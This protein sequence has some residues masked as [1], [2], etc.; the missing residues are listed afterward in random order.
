MRFVTSWLRRRPRRLEPERA[1]ELWARC[2]PPLPHNELM[3]VEQETMEAMI[4]SSSLGRVL[5]VGTGTGRYLRLLR[6]RGARFLVG[7]DRSKAMLER[8][9][10]T[11]APLVRGDAGALPLG[12]NA[13]DLVVASLV[14]G[15]IPD[16]ALW[17]REMAR[18]LDAGGSLLYSDFHP[19]WAARGWE[20]TFRSADGRFWRVP[21]HAHALEDHRD[22]HAAWG[23]DVVE[24]REA[25]ADAC[26]VVHAKKR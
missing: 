8:A 14:V 24:I 1:Y 6:G 25:G 2:Y 5:D 26:I 19:S 4:P 3:R 12:G 22:A 18:V 15:D 21:F 16:L 23:L 7:L 20:R 17:A 11:S 9:R 10:E 13:F